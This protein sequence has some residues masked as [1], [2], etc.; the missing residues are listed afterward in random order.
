VQTSE[1][2]V[3]SLCA[4][5]CLTHQSIT[6][7]S[8]PLIYSAKASETGQFGSA[9]ESGSETHLGL[10]CW[11]ATIGGKTGARCLG[12]ANYH[13]N[14]FVVAQYCILACKCISCSLYHLFSC[15]LCSVDPIRSAVVHL[16][17]LKS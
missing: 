14:H 7:L 9:A 11:P 17:I 8:L 3:K 13:V 4:K 5:K 2:K 16:V 12:M 10:V 15:V 6:G 1:R